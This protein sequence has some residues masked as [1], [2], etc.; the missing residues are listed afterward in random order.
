[1][2]EEESREH[3]LEVEELARLARGLGHPVRVS[4]IAALVARGECVCGELVSTV[5]RAQSTVSQHLRILRECGL[6]SGEVDGP[7]VCYCVNAKA[8][9]RL[10]KLLGSLANRST[11]LSGVR[12]KNTFKNQGECDEC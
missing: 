6:V 12:S 9:D 10:Q 2:L 11:P 4:L 5:P 8:L 3:A 7:R 1:M